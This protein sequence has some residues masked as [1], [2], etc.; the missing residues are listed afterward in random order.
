[1]AVMQS[2]LSPELC[3]HPCRPSRG[4]F[5]REGC[6]ASILSV[7][8]IFVFGCWFFYFILVEK[9][10]NKSARGPRQRDSSHM[11]SSA[12]RFSFAL[13]VHGL[14]PPPALSL[15][16]STSLLTSLIFDRLQ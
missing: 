13:R 8:S 16:F 6:S 11:V 14:T 5:E 4:G 2:E 3:V 7:V 15:L 9:S 12:Q 1:M 10:R